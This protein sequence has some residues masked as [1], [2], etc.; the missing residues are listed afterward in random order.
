M[1]MV[2]TAQG[3]T[4][5]ITDFVTTWRVAAADLDITIP[6]TGNGYNYAVDWGDSMS[7]TAQNGDATHTYATP[8]SYTVR[9]SG[10]FPRFWGFGNNSADRTH[11]TKIIAINQWGNQRWTSMQA[12]FIGSVNL[13][14][15]ATD[16]PD[17][18]G[19][20]R[21][22]SMF[23]GASIFNQDISGWDVSNVTN[24]NFVF[25][26]AA[27]FNQDISGWDV[28]RVTLM[29]EMF[30]NASAFNQD[31]GSWNVG[32][33][34]DAGNMFAAASA[35]NQDI[36]SWNVSNVINMTGMFSATSA[37][38]QAIGNW[39]VS[40]VTDMSN[41]FAN[42]TAFD[43]DI[44]DWDVSSVTLLTTMFNNATLSTANYDSLLR[45][46]TTIDDDETALQTGRTFHGGNSTYC[47]G[48]AARNILTAD[49]GLNWTITADGGQATGCS[50]VATLSALSLSTGGLNETFDT[51]TTTYTTSVRST[52]T[53][54]TITATAT[55]GN[56]AI[57][58]TGTDV[59]GAALTVNAATGVVS[60]LTEGA[61]IITIAVTSQDSTTTA[62][63]TI[64]V[65]QAAPSL[66]DFV[67]TWR[68][69]AADLGITIPTTSG[70]YNYTVDW[71]DSMS[72]TGQ[73][74]DATHTYTTPGAYTVR[75]SGSFPRFYGFG[76]NSADRTHRDKIIAINQWG[77]QQ[78]TSMQSAF[79]NSVNLV[80][81]AT[82]V[83]DL[84]GV[85]SMQG[86]FSGASIFNQDISG[87][88]VSN[89]TNMRSMFQSASAFNQD[90][91]DWNVSSVT[92]MTEM[93][94]SAS[95]FNQDIGDWNVSSVANM[96]GMFA[97]ADA[98]NQDIGNWNVSN[99]TDMGGMFGGADAFNQDIG[100]WNVS[101]VTDMAEMF[102]NTGAFNQ[103]IGNWD[104]SN[105]TNMIEMFEGATAFDQD[106]G[107][108]NV[109]SATNLSLMFNNAT[110]STANYDALLR[111][112]TTIDDDETALQT[113]RTFHGGNSTYCATAARTA[114]TGAPNNWTITSDGGQASDADCAVVLADT[115]L[116]GLSLL[117][118]SL[119]ETFA[120]A[121][122]AYTANVATDVES[123]T[124]TASTNTAATVAITG[125]DTDGEALTVSNTTVS[126][127]TTGE[128]IITITVTAENGTTTQP[129][130]ITVTRTATTTPGEPTPDE[131]AEQVAAQ[132][133]VN[134][135]I[136][137]ETATAIVG[138]LVT[139]ISDRVGNAA[140]ARTGGFQF[141]GGNS[142]HGIL[143]N[144]GR[145]VQNDSLDWKKMMGNSS[146]VMPL[147]AVDGGGDTV[148][149]TT[150]WGGGNYTNLSGGS[151]G[152]VKWDGDLSGITLGVD[153][154]ISSG[155]LLGLSVSQS[156][157][158]FDYTDADG[159]KGTHETDLT[160]INPYVN[161]QSGNFDLWATVGYGSG[162]V[163]YDPDDSAVVTSTEDADLKMFAFG[164]NNTITPS[165]ES[166]KIRLKSEASLG[167]FEVEGVGGVDVSVS[168]LRM[169][170]EGSKE[171]QNETGNKLTSSVEVGMRYDGG[172]GENT[173]FGVELGGALKYNNQQGVRL[174]GRAHW[175][176]AHSE[177]IDEWGVSGLIGFG[178]G[179]A[180]KSGGLSFSLS[181][182]WG[183]ESGGDLWN[184][185]ISNLSPTE[186]QATTFMATEI[187]Y[188]MPTPSGRGL[189]T[190][191]TR[192]KT[193][194]NGTT[195]HLGTRWTL[196][197]TATLN[198]E[199]GHE[200]KA[201]GEVDNTIKLT[202][203]LAL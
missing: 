177:E 150:I 196:N 117:P 127:L 59:S 195:H 37:F 190:P 84:S 51:A 38:N 67:T 103:D 166:I 143:V 181:T 12:A 75:I 152:Q 47:T 68:V 172:D 16:V 23:S 145:D 124:I 54:T 108:W 115:S 91:G 201:D 102:D 55:D 82:D 92:S 111:G 118:G 101:S 71:G 28:S 31:I 89:V 4:A 14:G 131:R 48:T 165:A 151:S 167:D 95:A 11:R 144:G 173:G 33:V 83:P 9:I 5:N 146:F 120:T 156:A 161:W 76:N 96:G 2:H 56:T 191:Y 43:Q 187:S 186:N 78:W 85:T 79:F 179:I 45:G 42:A 109:S 49:T 188:G 44:G 148:G 175:L 60:G 7:D 174:E 132:V 119:N 17:L 99:A 178:N 140:S 189:I 62:T 87:W 50:S 129:Y 134:E 185:D 18:S 158:S 64:T 171:H 73:N 138:N 25:S 93:F 30:S 27:A 3:Q 65:T 133:A 128:N 137:P 114:L 164:I 199:A 81:M 159:D 57:E 66:T 22:D 52:I 98:F 19:L 110:L 94:Q 80:G 77:N 63:Y 105:V 160:T 70:G 1:L 10:S 88:D 90:I 86:M 113:G 130:I 123:I 194:T 176:A 147:N 15:L 61:N 126:G 197:T 202:G 106:L 24:M 112:W 35:F 170:I 122:T 203:E 97:V 21:L 74:G 135:A 154:K 155:L 125:T 100:N 29:N 121:T 157:G 46:W 193:T 142:L 40:K 13:V 149:N 53:S 104:V 192:L 163:E 200:I 183:A 69:A 184:G 58:I 6:T 39:N 162:E 107:D 20:T 182:G 32:N 168:R 136:L 180:S 139:A 116:S 141:G 36:G 169:A 8:G 198:L 153:T 26:R 34:S 72:D 41:M